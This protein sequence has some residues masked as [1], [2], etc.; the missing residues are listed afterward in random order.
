MK[1]KWLGTAGFEFKTGDQTLLIDPYLS[2]NQKSSP[3]QEITPFN[4]K[5]ASQIF[6]SHGHFDHILDVPQIAGQTNAS[7]YCSKATA[8]FLRNY[9]I[10]KQQIKP[11][12]TEKK[13]FKFQNYSAQAFFSEHVK[14]DRKLVLSTFLKI[15]VQLFKYLPL[16]QR[17]PCGQVLSWRFYINDKII[18]FFGSAG[19]SLEELKKIGDKPIDILLLP[20]QGHSQI[21]RIG[22][23]YIKYLKPKIVIPHHHDN[24]FPPISK[25]VDIRPFVDKIKKDHKKTIVII[26]KINESLTF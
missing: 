15:N 13:I 1:L 12:L 5:K 11:V 17:F 19:S 7:I 10:D 23:N 21:C 20:M 26:P 16:F 3:K 22:L 24:F 2:R 9:P 25:A 6:I 8:E 18:Q 4:I 14:F